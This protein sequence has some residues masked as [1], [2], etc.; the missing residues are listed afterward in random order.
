VSNDVTVGNELVE[1][2][3]GTVDTCPLPPA[4]DVL[5]ME[6]E[7]EEELEKEFLRFFLPLVVFF[8]LDFRGRSI[9]VFI[10]AFVFGAVFGLKF[11][12]MLS[13]ERLFSPERETPEKRLLLLDVVL[14]FSLLLLLML[15]AKLFNKALL[16]SRLF[17]S[18][19]EYGFGRVE[20]FS[21]TDKEEAGIPTVLPFVF[22]FVVFF[23]FFPSRLTLLLVVGVV[24]VVMV[25]EGRLVPFVLLFFFLLSIPPPFLCLSSSLPL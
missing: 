17:I 12:L 10:F 20:F 14:Q 15:L 16:P 21:E 7:L 23:S 4:V 8:E 6:E 22:F 9:F 11:A 1:K 3:G 24:V 5:P 25:A 13:K 19:M 18:S 2:E